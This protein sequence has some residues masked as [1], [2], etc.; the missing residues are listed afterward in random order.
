MNYESTGEK[1]YNQE[2]CK[3]A[4]ETFAEM[5][6]CC[7]EE[8]GKGNYSLVD[9]SEYSSIFYTLNQGYKIPG[10]TE[11]IFMPPVYEAW[12]TYWSQSNQLRPVYCWMVRAICSALRQ[13]M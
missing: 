6:S 9:F 2:Y 10:G 8:G 3:K 11:A 13:T 4:A 7:R 5:L 12:G 1:T